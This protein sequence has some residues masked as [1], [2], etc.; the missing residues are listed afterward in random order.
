MLRSLPISDT[1]IL[2]G[3]RVR[4]SAD[5]L[6]AVLTL[7]G[8][9]TPLRSE[10]LSS[11]ACGLPPRRLCLQTLGCPPSRVKS[12]TS[13]SVLG[14]G[15]ETATLA[16]L[17]STLEHARTRGQTKLVDYLEAV[18]EDVVFEMGAAARR[19]GHM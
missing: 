2:W 14:E 7:R 1:S 9:G 17:V 11:S 15:T 4:P 16:W 5:K 3:A 8:K 10:T 12:S 18:V 13:D 19:R 6:P